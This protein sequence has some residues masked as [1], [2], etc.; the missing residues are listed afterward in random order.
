MAGEEER[1][2]RDLE[3]MREEIERMRALLERHGVLYCKRDWTDM[4]NALIDEE[5]QYEQ[6]AREQALEDAG[7]R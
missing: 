1:R 4:A 7:E 2:R 6:A 5:R 3:R